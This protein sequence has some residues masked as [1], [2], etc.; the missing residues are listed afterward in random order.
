LRL[1]ETD[2]ETFRFRVLG[3]VIN[4]GGTRLRDESWQRRLRLLRTSPSS[5]MVE[6]ET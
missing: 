2:Q 4:S 6:T 3:R 5:L 1:E